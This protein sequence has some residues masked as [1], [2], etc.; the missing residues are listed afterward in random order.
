MEV[1]VANNKGNNKPDRSDVLRAKDIVPPFD[2]EE[3]Q[4]SNSSEPFKENFSVS[5]LKGTRDSNSLEQENSQYLPSAEAANTKDAKK[6]QESSEVPKFDLA[7]D[8]MAGQRKVTAARRKA[9]S[10][11]SQV[12][13]IRNQAKVIGYALEQI[14]NAPKKQEKIIAEIVA[15]DIEKLRKGDTSVFVIPNT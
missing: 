10:Q 5:K 9:P 14:A 8:I 13:S 7:E 15:A 11:R 6:E 4:Q 1:M 2:R 12:T 3:S